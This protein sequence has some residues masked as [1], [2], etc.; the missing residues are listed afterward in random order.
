MTKGKT[1]RNEFVTIHA[2]SLD[3]R[4]KPFTDKLQTEKKGK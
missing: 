4:G 3:S 2:Y 1:W